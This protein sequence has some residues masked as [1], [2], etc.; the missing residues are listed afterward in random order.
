MT[1]RK[2]GDNTAAIA[3]QFGISLKALRLYEQLGM[4]KPP[5]S[6]AGWRS[7][8]PAEIERLHAILSFKQFGL[9]LARIA[10]LF[11]TGS[12]DMTQLLAVQEILLQEN[13]KDTEH[14]LRLTRIA[15]ERLRGEGQITTEELASI[16][17]K[18]SLVIRWSPE[19]EKLAGRIF[20]PDQLAK[21]QASDND[22]VITAQSS[23]FWDG[24]N[25]E[26]DTLLPGGDPLCEEAL[27]L[28][29]RIVAFIR[30]FTRGDKEMWNN[31]ARFWRAAVAD[32]HM[33]QQV[34]VAKSQFEFIGKVM[35]ELQR[36]GE[37][38]P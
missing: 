9:P 13:L 26:I 8:G 34:P 2:T 4:L 31:S 35:T 17:R 11:R 38:A 21:M 20:T 14:A 33:S 27:A 22:P 36:R 29:R 10:E 3:A 30:Q 32:P 5:R 16:I 23:V 28:G 24:I 1:A 12:A 19:L 37:L 18:I 6:E 15:Q 7:Y 25:A